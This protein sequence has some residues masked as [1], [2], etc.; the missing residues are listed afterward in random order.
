A[1]AKLFQSVTASAR[2]APGAAN[3]APTATAMIAAQQPMKALRGL[4]RDDGDLDDH[5]GA[6]AGPNR[7]SHRPRLAEVACVD[8]VEPREVVEVGEM[9]EAGDDIRERA[10]VLLEQGGDVGERLLCLLRDSGAG[11]PA[12]VA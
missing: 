6:E 2:A 1:F 12:A 8:L 11:E 9:H 5:S 7:R 10:A 4:V 3:A